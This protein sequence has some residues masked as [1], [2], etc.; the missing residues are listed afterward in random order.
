[1]V[2]N[3]SI[4]H[5]KFSTGLSIQLETTVGIARYAP[6]NAIAIMVGA[7]VGR[8]AGHSLT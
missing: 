1:M 7:Q 8:P 3:K 6:F 2:R 5:I 4:Q